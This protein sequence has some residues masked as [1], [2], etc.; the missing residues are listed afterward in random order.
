MPA[1]FEE[2]LEKT[3]GFPPEFYEDLRSTAETLEAI[4]SFAKVD[5][6]KESRYVLDHLPELRKER[7]E[8][9]RR[10]ARGM[11]PAA[12][13]VALADAD[14]LEKSAAKL[15]L[16]DVDEGYRRRAA[17]TEL[18]FRLKSRLRDVAKLEPELDP[19]RLKKFRLSLDVITKGLPSDV[20]SHESRELMARMVFVQELREARGNVDL[21]VDN[22]YKNAFADVERGHWGDASLDQAVAASGQEA[23]RPAQVLST[24]QQT[25][26]YVTQKLLD[27]ERAERIS[28]NTLL[29]NLPKLAAEHLSAKEYAAYRVLIDNEHLLDWRIENGK[30]KFKA[31][32]LDASDH[33][34]TVGK[35]LQRDLGYQNIRGANALVET[36][37][38]KL[39]KLVLENGGQE[40]K[41]TEK[42]IERMRK[43]TA[44]VTAD[45]EARAKPS[46]TLG[47][48]KGRGGLGV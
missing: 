23:D 31:I 42:G 30:A 20:G 45:P 33:E 4:A 9:L 27:E 46:P 40:V 26:D 34:N 8:S 29:R 22:L 2:L 41:Q 19:E 14:R 24:E 10:D 48:S 35:I 1:M 12:R 13:R 3:K 25:Q 7:A 16:P 11:D 43:S 5:V 21:A 17:L 18:S 15:A 36:T 37:I 39:N 32:Q 6:D 47:K 28:R 44:E 38:G